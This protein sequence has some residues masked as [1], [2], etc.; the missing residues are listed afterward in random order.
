VGETAVVGDEEVV[1]TVSLFNIDTVQ[2]IS[3]SFYHNYQ[4]LIATA[5]VDE[6]DLSKLTTVPILQYPLVALDQY[7]RYS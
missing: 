7:I 6:D 3:Q 1:T 5:A 4:E 2:L